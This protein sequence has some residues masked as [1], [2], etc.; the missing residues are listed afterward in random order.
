[1]SGLPQHIAMVMDGN[2]RW[3]TAQNRPRFIGHRAGA[4]RVKPIVEYCIR[5]G[6]RYLSLFAFSTENQSRPPSEVRFLMRLMRW[7]LSRHQGLLVDHNV[8][9]RVIGDLSQVDQALAQQIALTERLTE[10]NTGMTLL[11]ALHY[12]GRWDIVQA[13]EKLKQ[14]PASDLPLSDQLSRA[15]AFAEYPDPDLLIR[16]G[17]ERRMSNFMLWQ[18]AY[19]ELYFTDTLWPD[20]TESD[21]ARAL[22]FFSERQRRFGLTQEQREK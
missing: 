8:R 17:G 15:L 22:A 4:Y 18:L 16:S 13:V 3:A 21:V 2:G 14:A 11:I 12:S 9:L 1:M 5:R 19:T 7:S 20:I 6:I 10:K